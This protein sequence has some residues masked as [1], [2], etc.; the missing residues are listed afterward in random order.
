MT[1]SVIQ[2]PQHRNEFGR[3][4][5]RATGVIEHVKLGLVSTVG[6]VVAT[7]GLESATTLAITLAS[8]AYAILQ[9]YKA[10][11]DLQQKI[12][13]QKKDDKKPKED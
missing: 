8:L 10:W 5:T 11:L 4:R 7:T 13:D 12:K 6:L 9:A 3:N 2:L 1:I